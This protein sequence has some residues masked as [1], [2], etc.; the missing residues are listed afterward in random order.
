MVSRQTRFCPGGPPLSEL[1]G[2]LS[3]K[4]LCSLSVRVARQ[5]SNS[6]LGPVE[7]CK[8]SFRLYVIT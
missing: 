7:T 6:I 2:R 5:S 8:L 1:H 4:F 3:S